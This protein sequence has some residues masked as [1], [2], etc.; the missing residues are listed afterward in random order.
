MAAVT[1]NLNADNL[2]NKHGC[3]YWY[4][5]SLIIRTSIIWILV[6]P[7]SKKLVEFHC[8][9]Q[10]GGHLFNHLYI[11]CFLHSLMLVLMLEVQKGY[12]GVVL[13]IQTVH[14]SK[15]PPDQRGSDNQGCTAQERRK[16]LESDL[17]KLIIHKRCGKF[18]AGGLCCSCSSMAIMR[19]SKVCVRATNACVM[20]TKGDV[21][22]NLSHP[23]M[24]M[25]LII[26]CKKWSGQNRTGQTGSAATAAIMP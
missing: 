1:D 3:C 24:I 13:V 12:N 19:R 22:N 16:Q 26:L 17:A 15:Q 21:I 25:N 4:H 14:L 7:N 9:L 20:H 6:Y 18:W 10:Y 23:L 5:A 11:T 8:N 2:S